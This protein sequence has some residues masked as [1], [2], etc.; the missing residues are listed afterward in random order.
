L[1]WRNEDVEWDEMLSSRAQVD[2]KGMR[3][4]RGC[5]A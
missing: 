2:H 1:V 5:E 4:F 3:T